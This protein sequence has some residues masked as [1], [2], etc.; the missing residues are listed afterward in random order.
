MVYFR[1]GNDQPKRNGL[2]TVLTRGSLLRERVC[3]AVNCRPAVPSLCTT[4]LTL[5]SSQCVMNH[6]PPASATKSSLWP[7]HCFLR[8]NRT[9]TESVWWSV[10]LDAVA[11]KQGDFVQPQ[12]NAG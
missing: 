11:N 4:L 10:K 12:R 7:I 1:V 3:A 6:R 5:L 9:Q 8:P 2:F